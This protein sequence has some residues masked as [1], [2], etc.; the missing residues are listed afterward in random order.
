MTTHTQ[1][2]GTFLARRDGYMGLNDM[3]VMAL[4]DIDVYEAASLIDPL[5]AVGASDET[6]FSWM[7][8]AL[9][10]FTR[11]PSSM[12]ERDTTFFFRLS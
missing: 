2:T 5:V 1:R 4:H 3:N 7:R 9:P 12:I 8:L 11:V 10:C 6:S